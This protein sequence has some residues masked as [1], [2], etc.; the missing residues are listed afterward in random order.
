MTEIVRYQETG[1]DPIY[2]LAEWARATDAVHQV[3][4]K[5][6]E[7][8]FC[9]KQF[10]GAPDEAT[11]AILAGLEVGLQPLASLRSFDVIEGVAAP[12]A[13]TLRAVAQSYGH[14]IVLLESTDTRCRMKGKRKGSSEWQEVLWT[15]DRAKRQ[16]LANKP[17]WTKM[18]QSMLVAR[19][20][21]EISRLIASDAI[22][23]L[24]Y[25]VEE[26]ADG[27]DVSV[28]LVEQPSSSDPAPTSGAKVMRRS[29]PAELPQAPQEPEN[30]EAEQ[31][32][33]PATEE[34][35]EQLAEAQGGVLID[36]PVDEP[37]EPEQAPVEKAPTVEGTVPAGPPMTARQRGQI[38]ALFD[39]LGV[40]DADQQ[41]RGMSDVL[42]RVV[43]SRASLTKDEAAKVIEAL[44]KFKAE[45]K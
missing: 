16:G 10:R 20:T 42:G 13:Q 11:A 37:N 34:A 6:V 26:I 24:G 21:S 40:E 45:S 4:L 8:S 30:V 18:P 39:D 23:G 7:T 17:N 9:P 1:S 15:V 22:L 14:E 36:F 35:A 33:A 5:L 44:Q 41:K 28:A 3:A 31:T 43:E 12:R 27:A 38:F 32:P 29:R 25:S 19:A 2:R